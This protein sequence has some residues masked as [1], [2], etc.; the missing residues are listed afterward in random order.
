MIGCGPLSIP[1]NCVLLAIKL[2]SL[3]AKIRMER[4]DR[5]LISMTSSEYAAHYRLLSRREDLRYEFAARLR[6]LNRT[7][8]KRM[9]RRWKVKTKVRR[10]ER[11]AA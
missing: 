3:D 5:P 9:E 10:D 1:T 11:W 7:F 4:G 8:V 2:A 6:L